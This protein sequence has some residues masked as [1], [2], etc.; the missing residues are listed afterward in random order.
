M[1]LQGLWLEGRRKPLV[2]HAPPDG[3]RP[4]RQMLGAAL[5]FDELLRFK[6]SFEP[7]RHGRPV[8]VGQVCVTPFRTSHLDALRQQ[9]QRRRPGH[10]DAFCFLIEA[11]GRRVGHSADLGAVADLAPLVTRPLDLLVCELC[12]CPAEAL[13]A[14][15]RDKPIAHIVFIHLAR[16]H[17]ADLAALRRQARRALPRKR[18]SFPSEGDQIPW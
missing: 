14:W 6:L 10:F 18:L 17:W 16:A 15:L 3:I 5:L 13:F 9:H 4:I 11:G 1:L 12:H 7:L 8:K 2:V